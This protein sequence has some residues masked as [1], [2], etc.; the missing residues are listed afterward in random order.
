MNPYKIIKGLIT[1]EKSSKLQPEAKYTFLVDTKANKLQIK[2]AI[3]EIYKV[4]VKKVNTYI[5]S[6]KLR[7][8][9]YQAGYTPNIK[10]AIVS[11]Q[12][13]QKIEELS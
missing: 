6:G 12:E 9:R 7:R 13:G 4:K 8:I 10:K 5:I 11:L 2:K 3:Q 1:T